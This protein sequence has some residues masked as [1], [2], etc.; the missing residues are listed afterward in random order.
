MN[1]NK[2]TSG[3][4]NTIIVVALCLVLV[5][6]LTGC[7]LRGG[8]NNQPPAVPT[9]APA[10]LPTKTPVPPTEQAQPTAEQ[11]QPTAEPP[12]A[13]PTA[14]TEAAV[15]VE[16]DTQGDEIEQLLDLLDSQNQKA[17]PLDDVPQ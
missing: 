7:G 5:A 9:N 3:N 1:R 16:P 10:H 8:Q 17:D 4:R 11:A 14:T 13:A 6:G 12:T 15:V 2:G